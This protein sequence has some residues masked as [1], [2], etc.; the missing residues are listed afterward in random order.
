MP[1]YKIDRAL[2]NDH[3]VKLEKHI[4][5][6]KFELDGNQDEEDIADCC[7][8]IMKIIVRSGLALVMEQKDHIQ[9]ISIHR[10]TL[11]S[12]FYPHKEPEMKQAL[13]YAIHPSRSPEEIVRFLDRF[14]GW[15]INEA[16]QWLDDFN[17]E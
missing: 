17:P 6:A 14:R 3:L 7:G 13:T 10:I 16:N 4:E 11:F 1:G 9:E 2:A 5:Q 8:W 12:T 15:M